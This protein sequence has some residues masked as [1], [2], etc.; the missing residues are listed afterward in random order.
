MPVL[1][2][3]S[4]RSKRP[5]HLHPSDVQQ[6]Q[7]KRGAWTTRPIHAVLNAASSCSSLNVQAFQ[8]HYHNYLVTYRIH[9]V[10]LGICFCTVQQMRA[11]GQIGCIHSMADMLNTIQ[12]CSGVLVCCGVLGQSTLAVTDE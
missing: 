11:S 9:R 12:I 10:D 6:D 3:V 1:M 7:L 4:K 2:P 5:S 8:A